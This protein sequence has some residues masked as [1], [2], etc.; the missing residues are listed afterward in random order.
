MCTAVN[1]HAINSLCVA[2]PAAPGAFGYVSDTWQSTYIINTTKLAFLEAENVCQENGGHLVSY[3]RWGGSGMSRLV[4]CSH[5]QEGCWTDMYL[6][7]L[8]ASRPVDLS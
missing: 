4:V 2:H 7:F 1:A 5:V 3:S 6:G 8:M